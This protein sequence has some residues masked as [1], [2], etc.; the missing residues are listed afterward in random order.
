MNSDNTETVTARVLRALRQI[1]RAIEIRSKNLTREYG[2]TGPQ[3]I[4]LKELCGEKEGLS[5]GELSRRIHLSHPTVTNMIDR[6]I[7]KGAV[8][9]T[10]S[11]ADKRKVIVKATETAEK[12]L[13]KKPS[14]LQDTFLREFNDLP[15]W[16]QHLILSSILKVASML[17]ADRIKAEPFLTAEQPSE[18]FSD[19]GFLS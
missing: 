9:R 14:L 18:S 6:L 7:K 5:P 10:P 13:E 15:E 17:E 8:T 1:F 19:E 2:Y 3:L 12:V 4:L 16:E 11:I